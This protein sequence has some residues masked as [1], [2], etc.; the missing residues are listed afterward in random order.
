MFSLSTAAAA[1]DLHG[2]N[3]P[4]HNMHAHNYGYDRQFLSYQ[5]TP[6]MG[7]TSLGLGLGLGPTPGATGNNHTSSFA[8]MDQYVDFG[9]ANALDLAT[10]S[11][12]STNMNNNYSTNGLGG[13]MLGLVEEPTG[14]TVDPTAGR[15]YALQMSPSQAPHQQSQPQQPQ[16]QQQQQQQQQQQAGQGVFS[17]RTSGV[18]VGIQP[19]FTQFGPTST[20]SQQHSSSGELFAGP[21]SSNGCSNGAG[22]VAARPNNGR[23]RAS[24]GGQR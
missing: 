21:A 10:V 23:K 5:G 11:N 22:P 24:W 6:T 8:G 18:G 17:G 3:G 9:T 20:S 1:L 12:N 19:S 16:P 15:S 7:T 4:A 14:M 2:F 13:S